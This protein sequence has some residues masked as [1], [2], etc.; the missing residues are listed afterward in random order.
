MSKCIMCEKELTGRQKVSCSDKCRM[1]FKR[2]VEAEQ[3]FLQ[4]NPNSEPEQSQSEQPKANSVTRPPCKR[5]DVYCHACPDVVTCEYKAKQNTALP[6]DADYEG[7][8][9]DG[10]FEAV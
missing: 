7:V 6:G 1:Q 4:S 9:V 10:V 8:C 5:L 2:Q 3:E